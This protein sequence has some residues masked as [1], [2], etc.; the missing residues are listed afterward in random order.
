M[1]R[2]GITMVFIICLGVIPTFGQ[3][4][5]PLGKCPAERKEMKDMTPEERAEERTK[6]M[7][8]ELGL[9]EDQAKEIYKINLE[10]AKKMDEL[11][12]ERKQL[13]DKFKAEH[14]EMKASVD[15]VL[16]PEQLEKHQTMMSK[17]K[18]MPQKGCPQN[19]HK[20]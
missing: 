16:T 17:H 12:A 7:T 18:G 19:C 9:T 13:H 1:K 14:E 4:N 8:E 6:R 15:K 10:H 5:P 3:D 11:M 20:P 2:A